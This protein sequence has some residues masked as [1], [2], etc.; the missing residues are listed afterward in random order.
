MSLRHGCRV[1][2]PR[3]AVAHPEHQLIHAG[4]IERRAGQER[5]RLVVEVHDQTVGDVTAFDPRVAAKTRI[6]QRG[7]DNSHRGATLPLLLFSNRHDAPSW[8]NYELLMRRN[9]K[10]PAVAGLRKRIGCQSPPAGK[11]T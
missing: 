10:S 6:E 9:A 3:I 1:R 2:L 4:L 8:V 11:G 5:H 7:L